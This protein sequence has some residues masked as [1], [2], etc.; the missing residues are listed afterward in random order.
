MRL[1]FRGAQHELIEAVDGAAKGGA[2]LFQPSDQVA[3][4]IP[5][6]LGGFAGILQGEDPF[7]E[8]AQGGI[9]SG[10]GQ[11]ALGLGRVIV[12]PKEAEGLDRQVRPRGGLGGAILDAPYI[13]V[14]VTQLRLHLGGLQFALQ[15]QGLGCQAD[16]GQGLQP[17]AGDVAGQGGRLARL[18]LHRAQGLFGGAVGLVGGALRG[19]VAGADGFDLAVI[20][21][22]ANLLRFGGGGGGIF[23]GVDLAKDSAAVVVEGGGQLLFPAQTQGQG[24][25]ALRLGQTDVKVG[26]IDHDL[27][28]LFGRLAQV[29]KH[30]P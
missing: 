20:G 14:D 19:F 8:L 4:L 22:A 13:A 3:D 7:L 25:V 10:Q 12:A 6:L 23:Q 28:D 18:L 9:G 24:V 30:Q 15:G 16:G 29:A 17:S 21:C 26:V 27:L 2:D 1:L 5:G 11:G